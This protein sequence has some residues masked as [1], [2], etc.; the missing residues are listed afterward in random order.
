MIVTSSEFS[1]K[2]TDGETEQYFRVLFDNGTT[3]DSSAG[4]I[5]AGSPTITEYAFTG[6]DPSFGEVL[7]NQFSL[8]VPKDIANSATYDLSGVGRAYIGVAT[9]AQARS[10]TSV[11]VGDN[12][13]DENTYLLVWIY[14]NGGY[15]YGVAYYDDS[16]GE[17][18]LPAMPASSSQRILYDGT[19]ATA[20]S[21]GTDSVLSSDT[22]N[23]IWATEVKYDETAGTATILAYRSD[24]NGNFV[25]TS[26]TVPGTFTNGVFVPPINLSDSDISAS[27]FYAGSFFEDGKEFCP[28]GV[29]NFDA[30][31][32]VDGETE[33]AM[34]AH[35]IIESLDISAKP[36]LESVAANTAGHW[37]PLFF[38]RRFGAFT[39]E[40]CQA[41]G[42]SLGAASMAYLNAIGFVQME[43]MLAYYV[44]GT[45]SA[46]YEGTLRNLLSDVA[47][48]AGVNFR[49][50]RFGNVAVSLFVAGNKLENI[51]TTVPTAPTDGDVP[52]ERVVAGSWR[53]NRF[54]SPYI[55]YLAA[56]GADGAETR[57]PTGGSGTPYYLAYNNMLGQKTSAYYT[58]YVTRLQALPLYKPQTFDLTEADPSVV[59]GDMIFVAYDDDNTLLFPLM[60]QV[61]TFT[62][63]LVGTYC[64]TANRKRESINSSNYSAMGAQQTADS[65]LAEAKGKV[66]FLGEESTDLD[67]CTEPGFYDYLAAATNNP[68]SGAGG[69]LIVIAGPSPYIMQYALPR[70]SSGVS[71]AYV[72]QYT[73]GGTWGAW[74]QL[75]TEAP[76]PTWTDITSSALSAADTSKATIGSLKLYACGNMRL[77]QGYITA[78]NLPTTQTTVANITTGNRPADQVAVS[79]AWDSARYVTWGIV[80]TGGA[81]AIRSSTAYTSG[82]LRLNAM[83]LV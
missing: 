65:A 54:I 2:I 55:D 16:T 41:A 6:E 25:I 56:L 72:R 4:E 5:V 34:T 23:T 40:L 43:E 18:V 29:Y 79:C 68:V 21:D 50:D 48:A 13:S 51:E 15:Y 46:T 78:V 71:T 60:N 33:T 17:N 19:A 66:P 11:V 70:D 28:L 14:A 61:L 47:A 3:L 38:P 37:Q 77:L 59:A 83:W 35:D 32:M 27:T 30:T 62:G 10:S 76:A 44:D 73:S 74:A 1:Q 75:L 80:G 42:M 52:A 24:E 26:I 64:C 45:Y 57:Y 12:S 58:R 39:S 20:S 67:N 82:N 69:A 31:E 53:I 7:S 49:S 8:S 81:I 63:R 9:S 22:T 36:F